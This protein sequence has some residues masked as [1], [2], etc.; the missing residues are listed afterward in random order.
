MDLFTFL[1][2][3]FIL[4]FSVIASIQDIKKQ[5]VW[6]LVIFSG[7]FAVL[8]L[9]LLLNH[10]NLPA[11]FLS[12]FVYGFF[13]FCVKVISKDRF[14]I[15]DIYFGIFQGICLSVK[16]LPLCVLLEVVLALVILNKRLCKGGFPFIP[17]MAA[18]LV[19]CNL[20]QLVI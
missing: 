2:W 3:A 6:N 18:S 1:M 11:V 4:I 15:A 13:Y 9:N 5:K 17:F 14:G 10:K 20:L 19:I 16:I 7:I 12:A 8:F